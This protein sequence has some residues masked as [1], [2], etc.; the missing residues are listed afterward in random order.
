MNRG[1]NPIR[2]FDIQLGDQPEFYASN[3]YR[4]DDGVAK[5]YGDQ[6]D[7]TQDVLRLVVKYELSHETMIRTAP[8][9]TNDPAME[10]D[11]ENRP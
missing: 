2:I 1:K 5:I 8:T 10:C 3:Q 11:D 4:V 7:V 6:W 9:E